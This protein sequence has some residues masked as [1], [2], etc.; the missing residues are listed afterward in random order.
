LQPV[1]D[2]ALAS[3]VRTLLDT[4][5]DESPAGLLVAI[6]DAPWLDPP[7]QR[8]LQFAL[9]RSA[10]G[11]RGVVTRRTGERGDTSVPLDL[12][13]HTPVERLSLTPLGV[14]PLHRL[15]AQRFGVS[16]S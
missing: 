4:T 15:L 11:V 6:D 5:A 3:A 2:R 13:D 1:D 14:G 9:R 7:T 12:D 8:A 10:A 16:L